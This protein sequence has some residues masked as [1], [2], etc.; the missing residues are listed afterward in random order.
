[1]TNNKQF[2]NEVNSYFDRYGLD[3]E[4]VTHLWDTPLNRSRKIVNGVSKLSTIAEEKAALFNSVTS[5]YSELARNNSLPVAAQ[6]HVEAGESQLSDK[7]TLLGLA[8]VHELF[9]GVNP[10][11]PMPELI[12][13]GRADLSK[14]FRAAVF[15]SRMAYVEDT[16]YVSLSPK[17]LVKH[18]GYPEIDAKRL[19]K[20]IK[21]YR[22]FEEKTSIK[23]LK[24]NAK[25]YYCQVSA[26]CT[27]DGEKHMWS[28]PVSDRSAFLTVG[29]R[30]AKEILDL[31]D[32]PLPSLSLASWRNISKARYERM[33]PDNLWDDLSESSKRR[34]VVNQIRHSSVYYIHSWA[35]AKPED[36][37]RLH[38]LSFDRVMRKIIHA[39][40]SLADECRRQL[41]DRQIPYN[42]E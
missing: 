41:D 3:K 33:H 38:E 8:S 20:N 26:L 4:V 16:D 6:F 15:K 2:E 19:F 37:S 27:S 5:S 24:R 23:M 30:S 17:A 21:S 35:I 32:H 7:V 13:K 1:M 31:T 11:L 28:L 34:R 22:D 9:K 36:S 42:L 39:Y 25:P 18:L 40:P 14:D 29:D 10:K 12:T